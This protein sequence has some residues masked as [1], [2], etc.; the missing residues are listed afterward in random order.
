MNDQPEIFGLHSN[1][2]I[3]SG[4]KETNGLMN[5]LLELLPR[6]SS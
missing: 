4:I 5:T 2:K 1:A 3:T 6:D